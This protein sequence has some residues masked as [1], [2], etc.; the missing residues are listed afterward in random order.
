MD[1]RVQQVSLQAIAGLDA[2][3]LAA[4]KA[5]GK[6]GEALAD[7]TAIR[8]R[9]GENWLKQLSADDAGIAYADLQQWYARHVGPMLPDPETHAQALGFQTLSA[10]VTQI[11][12]QYLLG[13]DLTAPV[14]NSSENGRRF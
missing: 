9:Y 13:R 1:A 8:E 2:Y 3:L 6:Y 11:L 10:F 4:L 7:V 14:A 5:S 12:A